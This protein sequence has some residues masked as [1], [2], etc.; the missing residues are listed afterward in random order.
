MIIEY[1]QVPDYH[2]PPAFNWIVKSPACRKRS[3]SKVS[4]FASHPEVDARHSLRTW[5]WKWRFVLPSYPCFCGETGWAMIPCSSCDLG[6]SRQ[7]WF[8]AG[9]CEVPKLFQCWKRGWPQQLSVNEHGNEISTIC[10]CP[11]EFPLPCN[12]IR[13]YLP[14]NRPE[15][16]NS[17][18]AWAN[19]L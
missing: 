18:Q 17:N 19:L 10:S 3:S 11:W 15:L 14:E 4:G 7:D 6:V 2:V 16:L 8:S 1:L 13:K 5:G 9:T 12:I